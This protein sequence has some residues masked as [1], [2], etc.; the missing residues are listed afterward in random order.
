MSL[1]GSQF[2]RVKPIWKSKWI[3]Q[4]K[5][6]PKATDG[7]RQHSPGASLKTSVCKV[8]LERHEDTGAR[9]K[10]SQ[11]SRDTRYGQL[12]SIRCSQPAQR[13]RMHLH[14]DHRAAHISKYLNMWFTV[15]RIPINFTRCWNALQACYLR[16]TMT[17]QCHLIL[18]LY[19]AV[20]LKLGNLLQDRLEWE[21]ER[22]LF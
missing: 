6:R 22:K 20:I 21:K 5:R 17:S 14:T 3:V 9:R 10:R 18:L 12:V 19:Q 16:D 8:S 15:R 11:R 7:K 1:F 4:S 13:L 2:W